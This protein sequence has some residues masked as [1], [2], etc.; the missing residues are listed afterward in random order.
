M[1]V[2]A[3]NSLKLIDLNL[4]GCE[5]A[6][7]TPTWEA[8]HTGFHLW[9]GVGWGRYHSPEKRNTS[10]CLKNTENGF[11]ASIHWGMKR[12]YW[13]CLNN[14]CSRG[15]TCQSAPSLPFMWSS[16]IGNQLLVSAW[17]QVSTALNCRK[18]QRLANLPHLNS[19]LHC[20]ILQP[21]STGLIEHAGPLGHCGSAFHCSY[22][23]ATSL[24]LKD[25]L[26]N[27]H[28]VNRID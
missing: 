11:R 7:C 12:E 19:K 10:M 5:F 4:C 16:S 28:P 17:S 23:A 3:T 6:F 2:H 1:S 13:G 14:W 25:S 18:A 27:F 22:H 21:L 24:P 15:K 8:S 26:W 9:G 20:N